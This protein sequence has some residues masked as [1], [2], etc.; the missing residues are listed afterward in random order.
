[1]D[2]KKVKEEI[3]KHIE[4]S[5]GLEILWD[6]QIHL[7]WRNLKWKIETDKGPL[8]VKQYHPKRYP[9]KKLARVQE[10]LRI[11]AYLAEKGI[12]CPKPLMYKESYL[13]QTASDVYYCLTPYCEGELVKPG[14]VNL[15]QMYHLGK[16]IGNMHKQLQSIPTCTPKWKPEREKLYV[17]WH[18]NWNRARMEKRSNYVLQAI[19]SQRTILD[20]LDLNLFHHCKV[21]WTHWDLFVENILFFC[22]SVSAILDFDRVTIIYP[23]LDIS[24]AILSCALIDNE[25]R[26]NAVS[27]F[28]KGYNQYLFLHEKEL[29]RSMKLLWCHESPKWIRPEMEERPGS[30][31][32]FAHEILWITTHWDELDEMFDSLPKHD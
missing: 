31:M 5:F 1:M 17:E 13:I 11:Q 10:G 12:P 14:E 22:D 24:R 3:W 30:A 29:A 20:K 18:K 8:F 19:E 23:E 26:L 2:V 6:Q 27:A 21:S 25:L 32:R 15:E 9:I 16:V 4:N 28:L 7:G